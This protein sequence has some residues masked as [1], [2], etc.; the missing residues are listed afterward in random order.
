M[1]RAA[2]RRLSAAAV[3]DR[4]P[5][6]STRPCARSES[7]RDDGDAAAVALAGS[8]RGGSRRAPQRRLGRRHRRG[9]PGDGGSYGSGVEDLSRPRRQ[10]A[11]ARINGAEA[12]LQEEMRRL[13]GIQPGDRV[14]VRVRHARALRAHRAVSLQRPLRRIGSRPPPVR[15]S[16]DRS[17]PTPPRSPT[18]ATIR[19]TLRRA[20]GGSA[21]PE[22][23]LRRWKIAPRWGT[24]RVRGGRVGEAQ[25]PP[26]GH[27]R[28]L[29][30]LW[31]EW[32]ELLDVGE[33]WEM[34]HRSAEP[35]LRLRRPTSL[36]RR[37]AA[38]TPAVI[39]TVGDAESAGR[40]APALASAKH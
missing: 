18:R 2:A 29:P 19:R 12:L 13:R 33:M 36:R 34:P 22:R 27:E 1:L 31:K 9:P 5:A 37:S 25:R 7:R 20:G 4:P 8:A 21:L 17:T 38:E 24:V 35:R 39:A 28:V 14:K 11:G 23:R 32:V 30:A 16:I 40:L 3:A 10:L 26:G 15:A 6:R